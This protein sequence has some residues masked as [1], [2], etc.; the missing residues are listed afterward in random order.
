VKRT[1]REFR[2]DNVTDWAAALTYYGVLAIFPA[3]IAL[4]SI[5]GLIGQS[6][7]QSLVN[8]LGKVAPGPARQIFTSAVNNLQ[9]GRGT[10]GLL[11]IVGLA[12]AIWSASG[13]ISAFM[14]ASNSIYDIKE[15]R[16]IWM[17]IPIR[18][19]VTVVLLLMLAVSA[20]AVVLTGGLAKQV[21][22]LV[23]LGSTAL[24]VWDIAK[25]P[26]LL[27]VVSLMF[28]LLY[29]SAPNVKQAGFRWVSPGGLFGVLIWVIAS[30]L[31]A[32]YVANFS[33]Y[34]KTYGSLAAIIVFLVWLWISN[35]A[36]LLGAELNAEME[37]G[38][39]I[40][41]GHPPEREPFVEPRRSADD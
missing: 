24:Q 40:E 10:A 5:L 23:G 8:N 39:Q 41:A 34:N 19:V 12:G 3:I 17:T 14:R 6:V 16:P 18:V 4:V 32:F 20:V 31:F 22:N 15:G 11:L 26:V 21:G 36:L 13:Y 2:H 1:V 35:I 37:R 29:W 30:A 38:R 7:T 25:W 9:H 33:S 28:A 27:I